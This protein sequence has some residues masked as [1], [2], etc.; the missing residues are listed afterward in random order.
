MTKTVFLEKSY[1]VASILNFKNKY[2]N[3]D[4]VTFQ[5]LNYISNQ[6]Q[7]QI[8]EE[9]RHD[10]SHGFV[11]LGTNEREEHYR[12]RFMEMAKSSLLGYDIADD[13][14]VVDRLKESNP[15]LANLIDTLGLKLVRD[16]GNI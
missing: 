1:I 4:F 14:Q 10:A 16:T 11:I 7:K 5:E 15:D 8:N 9:L 3:E 2:L 12:R 6:I 13:Q